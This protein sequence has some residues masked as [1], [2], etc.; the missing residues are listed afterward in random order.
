MF[1]VLPSI[2]VSPERPA[3]YAARRHRH[4]SAHIRSDRV[5]R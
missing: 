4:R 5:N 1:A 3:A 2:E